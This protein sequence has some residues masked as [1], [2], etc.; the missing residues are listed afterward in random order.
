M[1]RTKISAYPGAWSILGAAALWGT[2][3]VATQA[4][5]DLS[6]TNALSLAFLR[7]A[8]AALLLM[9]LCWRLLGRHMWRIERR[10]ALLMLFMGTMQAAFQYCYLAAIS[11]CGVTISTLIALCIAPVMVVLLAALF[12]HE[13]VTLRTLCALLCALVGT[14]L[15]TGAPTRQGSFGDLWLGILLSLISAAGYAGVILGGRVLSRCY[16]PLQI[17]AAAFSSGAVILWIGLLTTHLVLRYP[18]QGWLLILYMGCIPT[19]LAYVLF[20]YGMRSTPATLTSIL[21]LCEPLMAALLAWIFFK[22]HLDLLGML[23]ALLLLGT[24]LLLARSGGE[25]VVALEK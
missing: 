7:L 11:K 9:L 23:G 21:T 8:I 17:N 20:Q 16:H 2:T 12:L 3:G 24:I 22:E 10:A 13:R 18:V 5:Y 25:T 15:L 6:S 4:V 1:P 14:G 19:A